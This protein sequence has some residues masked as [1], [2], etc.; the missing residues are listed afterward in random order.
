MVVFKYISLLGVKITHHRLI[1]SWYKLINKIFAISY[2]L[3]DA[4][5]DIQK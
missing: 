5:K 4:C 2:Y 1:S 3:F